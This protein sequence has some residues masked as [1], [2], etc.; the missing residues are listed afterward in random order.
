MLNVTT[1]LADVPGSGFT[2]GQRQF[3]EGGIG[4]IQRIENRVGAIPALLTQTRADLETA[5]RAIADAEQR[6]GQPFKHE[7]ALDQ[8]EKQLVAVESALTAMQEENG[9]TVSTPS[10]ATAL[11]PVTV[12]SLHEHKPA[13]R[14]VP[15]S[16][17]AE[18]TDDRR[19][20]QGPS[21]GRPTYEPPNL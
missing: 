9:E 20:P 8:T 13:L 7:E 11:A 1:T 3:S 15:S 4:L 12:Q 21:Q 6:I 14:C 17:N 16:V 18:H 5:R 10:P 19:L 2:L